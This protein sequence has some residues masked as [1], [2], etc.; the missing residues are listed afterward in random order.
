VTTVTIP[1]GV[2]GVK[3]SIEVKPVDL[4][5]WRNGM[6]IQS[7]MPYLSADQREMFISQTCGNCWDDMFAFDMWEDELDDASKT[8]D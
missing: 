1:C 6:A 2:C 3:Q 7:A 4:G 5:K 8:K